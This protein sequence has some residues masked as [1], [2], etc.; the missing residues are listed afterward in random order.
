MARLA[1]ISDAGS[2]WDRG[3]HRMMNRDRTNGNDEEIDADQ[4]IRDYEEQEP[5]ALGQD[6]DQVEVEWYEQ[7]KQDTGEPPETL[8]TG[9]DIDA[10][11][12]QA[13][14]GGDEVVG[15]SNPTPDQDIVDEIGKAV[16][17]TYEDTEPL[18]PEEKIAQRDQER[19]E[20]NPVSSEDYAQRQATD[21][22]PSQVETKQNVL[23]DE[24]LSLKKR[25]KRR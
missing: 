3:G 9:G 11:W 17:V 10:D 6:E 20:L 12:R 25:P 4:V 23:K 19:W 7:A 21:D 13:H 2:D 1:H 22:K 8:L 15:G 16:G 18:R 14:F 5:A 24:A